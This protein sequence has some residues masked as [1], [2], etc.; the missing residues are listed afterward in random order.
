MKIISLLRL[1]DGNQKIILYSEDEQKIIYSGKMLD[2]GVDIL[3]T[4]F[5]VVRV[6]VLDSDNTMEIDV[7]AR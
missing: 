4:Q 7:K 1:I 6:G 2:M 3:L 5:N